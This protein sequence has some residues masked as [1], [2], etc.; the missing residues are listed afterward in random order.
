[1]TCEALQRTEVKEF[2]HWLRFVL[3]LAFCTIISCFFMVA[4]SVGQSHAAAP[5]SVITLDPPT[6]WDLQVHAFDAQGNAL[7]EGRQISVAWGKSK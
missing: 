6:G 2:R 5:R 4:S 1:M 7:P 3:I